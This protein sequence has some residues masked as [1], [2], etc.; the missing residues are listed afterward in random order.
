[1]YVKVFG[2][3]KIVGL[4]RI[5][6]GPTGLGPGRAIN[7][8]G[9]DSGGLRILTLGFETMGSWS[10][11]AKEFF[12]TMGK[13]LEKIS[14]DPRSKIFFYQRI[15]LAIQKNN[16]ASIMGSIPEGCKMDEIFYLQS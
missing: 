12:T 1:M 2:S 15:S 3:L 16:A 4:A 13:K 8:A 7:S 9:P 11:E 6:S 14:G 5:L 10:A